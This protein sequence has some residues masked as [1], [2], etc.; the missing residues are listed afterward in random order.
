[1]SHGARMGPISHVGSASPL[2]LG[3]TKHDVATP[4][5]TEKER[6]TSEGIKQLCARLEVD[7][8]QIVPDAEISM[9]RYCAGY[10]LCLSRLL[11]GEDSI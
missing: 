1:M 6:C 3:R 10:L 4:E 8:K 2:L 5:Y 9:Y 7:F 11:L